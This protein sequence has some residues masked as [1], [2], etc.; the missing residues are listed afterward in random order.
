MQR[1]IGGASQ[2][3]EHPLTNQAHLTLDFDSSSAKKIAMDPL[4]GAALV[5]C[6][7]SLCKTASSK[8]TVYNSIPH[9]R[10]FIFKMLRFP[11]KRILSIVSQVHFKKGRLLKGTD[12]KRALTTD[13]KKSTSSNIV[14]PG[15]QNLVSGMRRPTAE[16]NGNWIKYLSNRRKFSN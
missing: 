8:R 12:F 7:I 10:I 6:A 3:N 11:S 2:K 9:S 4:K 14:N 16:N 15:A 5:I 13:V 1:E